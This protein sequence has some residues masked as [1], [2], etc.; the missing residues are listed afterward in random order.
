MKRKMP[1]GF[2]GAEDPIH[3]Y[4]GRTDGTQAHPLKAQR[5]QVPM[6]TPFTTLYWKYAQFRDGL[7][8]KLEMVPF[9]PAQYNALGVQKV[10]TSE[11][12][13]APPLRLSKPRAH[14]LPW[15]E[16]RWAQRQ[17]LSAALRASPAGEPVV[18]LGKAGLWPLSSV[19]SSKPRPDCVAR[20][21]PQMDGVLRGP[22]GNPQA[23]G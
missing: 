3:T 14:G 11:Q 17:E 19:K 21:N 23:I 4:T 6:V 22:R 20:I 8:K 15:K 16:N 18:P 13:S 7:A 2:L 10:F 12:P 1:M 9:R 5:Y